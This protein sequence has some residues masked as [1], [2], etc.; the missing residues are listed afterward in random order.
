[1][2]GHG[3]DWEAGFKD[4]S[5]NVRCTDADCENGLHCFKR[6]RKMAV[7][8]APRGECR[9]CGEKLVELER[10]RMRKLKDRDYLLESLQF[11]LIRH[12]FWHLNIDQKALNHAKRKGRKNL[13]EAAR[14]RLVSSVGGA[15]LF[16]DGTQTPMAGNTLFYAQHATASCCRTCIEYWHGIPKGPALTESEISYLHDLMTIYLDARLPDLDDDGI[17]VP[18]LR[19]K[20]TR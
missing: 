5:L 10:T 11:E 1:M 12:H 18:P 13:Y 19:G 8:N 9:V 15:N 3:D 6:T 14:S 4:V 16:R 17:Y 20:H 7:E 2:A